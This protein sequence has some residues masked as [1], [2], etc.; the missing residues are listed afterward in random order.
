MVQREFE[1]CDSVGYTVL[2][3]VREHSKTGQKA[4]YSMVAKK[5]EEVFCSF[6]AMEIR[7]K[8]NRWTVQISSAEH[9]VLD[10]ANLSFIN[11]SC[12]PNI[13]FDTVAMDV[14]CLKD[15]Q[16]GD[17]LTAFYPSTEWIMAEPFTC[18]CTSKD[19]AGLILGA[20]DMSPVT[21][22]EYK[23]VSHVEEKLMAHSWIVDRGVDV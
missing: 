23:L 21:L 22:E 5:A 7:E 16:P 3:E 20:K 10:P 2:G 9:V 8:A 19:C 14:I 11:H 17:E 6:G 4:Y 18:R 1:L 15:I 13:F 12:D